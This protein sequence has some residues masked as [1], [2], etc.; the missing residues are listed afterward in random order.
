MI[1]AEK[2]NILLNII[3]NHKYKLIDFLIFVKLKIR[4][5]ILKPKI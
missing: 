1:V 2:F 4:Y 5:N 3:K